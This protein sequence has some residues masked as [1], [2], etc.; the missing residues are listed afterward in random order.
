[1]RFRVEQSRDAG[2]KRAQIIY[3]RPD[4][5]SLISGHADGHYYFRARAQLPDARLSEWSAPLAVR[6]EHHPL[7]CAW[8][9]FF[10]GAGVFLSVL[11]VIVRGTGRKG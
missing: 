6:L 7:A 1:M 8:V 11:A 2:F 3:A 9:F 4:R 10:V 5:A